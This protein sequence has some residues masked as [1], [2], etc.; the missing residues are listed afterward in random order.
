MKK[1]LS[2]LLSVVL[3]FGSSFVTSAYTENKVI[4]LSNDAIDFITSK[5]KTISYNAI[6]LYDYNEDIIAYGYNLLPKGYVICDINGNIIECSFEN[7]KKFDEEKNYYVGPTVLSNK[8]SDLNMVAKS[9]RF[10]DKVKR[11]SQREY[12]IN[13]LSEQTDSTRS[14]SYR[15]LSGNL[16]L[17]NYNPD[18]ICGSTA[19]A[20]FF[21]YYNDYID[22]YMVLS[23]YETSDGEKLILLLEPHIDGDTPGSNTSDLVSGMNWYLRWKGR[24]GYYTAVSSNSVA[25]STYQNI[26]NSGRPTIV[27]LDEHPDYQEHWVVGYGYEKYVR[28]DRSYNYYIVNDG[29]GNRG[30]YILS[31]YVGD[32]AY[33]NHL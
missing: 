1:F 28:S 21:M 24:S 6:P 30:V 8:I 23:S 14:V 19:A 10:S 31:D 27:D 26:I 5:N 18:G 3:L 15:V 32:I 25:Y 22:D 4:R 9:L 13:T 17:Y 7:M 20:I 16:R 2:V 12:N 11:I 33:L 29:W